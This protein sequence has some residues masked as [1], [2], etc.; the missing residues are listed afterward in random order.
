MPILHPDNNVAVFRPREIHKLLRAIPKNVNR[1]RFEAL[2]YSGC[3][4]SEL[5]E[6]HKKLGR[7]DQNAIKVKNTKALVKEKFRFVQLNNQGM[8]AILYYINSQKPLPGYSAW[9]ENLKRWCKKAGIDPTGVCASSTRKTWES[10]LVTTYPEQIE[11]IFISQ[12][13]SRFIAL[14]HYLAFPFT[15]EDKKEMLYFVDGW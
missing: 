5:R 8:R 6:I 2:L 13:H 7:L 10:W 3:R 1:E 4:Y 14:K 11:R 9:D 12:G 15:P